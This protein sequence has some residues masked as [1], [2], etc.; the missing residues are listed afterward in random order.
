MSGALIEN[1]RRVND[2]DYREALTAYISLLGN[3]V[4]LPHTAEVQIARHL[5]KILRGSALFVD[6]EPWLE[7]LQRG[8][9]KQPSPTRTTAAPRF[10][11]VETEGERLCYVVDM[12]DSMCKPI[13]PA[14]RPPAAAVTGPRV[15]KKRELLDESDLPWHKIETRWDLAREHLRIALLR[16]S[17]DKHFA[18]VWFGTESGTL[19]S[20]KGMIKATKVNVD[21]VLAELD[22]I[23]PGPKD[24]QVA[25]DGKLRGR[26]NL[27]SGL[28]RAFG[29]AGKG[30]IDQ[31]AYVDPLTLTEGC[32][33]IFLLSDGDPSW[34]DFPIE[35]K[36][37]RE[38]RTIVDTE[39]AAPAPDQ[40]R[41][42][43]YGPY[44]D[45]GWIVD[46]T[47]RMNAFRRISLHCIGLG[48]ANEQLLSR[49]A[50][51]GGG[52]AVLVGQRKSSGKDAGGAKK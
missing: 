7:L 42:T 36:N 16:L 52:E 21:R 45:H 23:K 50:E 5:Q 47:K 18:V 14:T 9:V 11:G 31:F 28:R 15:K 24:E 6:P 22:T 27:H 41:I 40:Q 35:D 29:L 51:V 25:P 17:P 34:D 32:D 3:D 2:S 37:Y 4:G 30:F 46:D 12:S 38:M 13:D 20:C 1:R 10:F 43:Y 33:T 49:L 26:T 48:E 19:N 39:Y 44:V 8:D